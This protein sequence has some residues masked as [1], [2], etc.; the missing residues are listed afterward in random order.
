MRRERTGMLN[1][2]FPCLDFRNLSQKILFYSLQ[3]SQIQDKPTARHQCS[4]NPSLT[5]DIC[6]LESCQSLTTFMISFKAELHCCE[7]GTR[8]LT[9]CISELGGFVLHTLPRVCFTSQ[10]ADFSKAY[11]DVFNAINML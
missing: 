4:A 7:S 9:I 6:I 5:S 2:S 3:E 10:V 8:S 1:F 11:H